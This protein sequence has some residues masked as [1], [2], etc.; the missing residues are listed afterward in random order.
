MTP[1]NERQDK[2]LTRRQFLIYTSAATTVAAG[3]ILKTDAQDNVVGKV[4]ILNDASHAV[5]S[6]T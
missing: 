5:Y 4:G 1:Q 2:H 6:Y 3:V